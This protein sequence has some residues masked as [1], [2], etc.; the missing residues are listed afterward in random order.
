MRYS[1]SCDL[2]PTNFSHTF[3]DEYQRTVVDDEAMAEK[4]VVTTEFL[5]NEFP[6]SFTAFRSAKIE[7]FEFHVCFC[8]FY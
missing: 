6:E 7:T 3:I 1:Q 5:Q 2:M 4:L 8:L